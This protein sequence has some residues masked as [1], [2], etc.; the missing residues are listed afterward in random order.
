MGRRQRRRHGDADRSRTGKVLATIAVGGSP[1]AI[2][3][4]TRRVWVTVD[5]QTT[6]GTLASGGGH[7]AD[8]GR[9]RR[10]FHGPGARMGSGGRVVATPLRDLREAPQLPGRIRPSRHAAHPRGRAG[11]AGAL[12][13]RKDVHIHDPSGLSFLAAVEPAGHRADIQ[14]HDR[15]HTQPEDEKPHGAYLATSSA[16]ARTWPA[17]P[18]TSA[19]S[20]PT[21]TS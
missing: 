16:L 9:P 4:A 14:G 5:P 15:A 2:A 13:R 6:P 11:A 20:S 19:A 3:V 7:A 17:G 18:L 12:V 21:A 8:R 10:R 1:Q